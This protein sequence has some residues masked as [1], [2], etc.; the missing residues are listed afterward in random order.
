MTHILEIRIKDA[1]VG[2]V[3]A[4]K[5]RGG[6]KTSHVAT[7]RMK[8]RTGDIFYVLPLREWCIGHARNY[9]KVCVKT[10]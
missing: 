6:I 3:N 1:T 5:V 8:S 2:N 9:V 4:K 10:V 7:L